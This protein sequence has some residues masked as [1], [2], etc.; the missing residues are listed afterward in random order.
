MN[1]VRDIMFIL[2]LIFF[3]YVHMQLYKK[4]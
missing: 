3:L 2:F 1:G 4:E